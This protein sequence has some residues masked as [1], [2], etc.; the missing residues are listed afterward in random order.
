MCWAVCAP[1]ARHNTLGVLSQ[2][3]N[4][5]LLTDSKSQSGEEYV[6]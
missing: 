3:V 6:I 1:S 2:K 5:T 4:L